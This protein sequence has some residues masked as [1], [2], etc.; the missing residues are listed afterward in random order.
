MAIFQVFQKTEKGDNLM[1]S[2]V[3][4]SKINWPVIHSC[5]ESNVPDKYQHVG[6]TVH[7]QFYWSIFGSTKDNAKSWP[8][9][10]DSKS[11]GCKL[12]SKHTCRVS[13]KFWECVWK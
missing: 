8:S 5:A 3:L 11:D 7:F 1:L 13:L 2:F 9:S 6:K 4:Y 10:I 12:P